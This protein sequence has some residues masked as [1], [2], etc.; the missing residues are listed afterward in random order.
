MW[1]NISLL[2]TFSV[3]KQTQKLFIIVHV[4]TGNCPVSIKVLPSEPESKNLFY[5]SQLSNSVQFLLSCAI[6][7]D[8]LC[9]GIQLCLNQEF[10]VGLA[11]FTHHISFPLIYLCLS[12]SCQHNNSRW[13]WQLFPI[14][15]FLQKVRGERKL[16]SESFIVSHTHYYLFRLNRHNTYQCIFSLNLFELQ[17]HRI[18]IIFIQAFITHYYDGS[19][20]KHFYFFVCLLIIIIVSSH[21]STTQHKKW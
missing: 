19:W 9:S 17:L 20:R 1:A 5:F 2:W 13:H 4:L 3:S 18:G 21:E 11:S 8:Y 7:L 15:H 14:K 10:V 12:P 6:L 16:Q